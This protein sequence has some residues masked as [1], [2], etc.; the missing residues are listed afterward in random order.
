MDTL[1]NKS[2]ALVWFRRDL[3]L[4]D[5]TALH[6]ALQEAER[7]YCVFVFDS[8]IL[9]G[10]PPRDRRVDFIHAALCELDAA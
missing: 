6:Y 8:D 4:L 10:L 7:V 2:A 1:D 5:H 3:R 9:A